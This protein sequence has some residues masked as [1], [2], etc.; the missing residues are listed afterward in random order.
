MKTALALCLLLAL[1][2]LA[3]ETLEPVSLRGY[4]TVSATYQ[5]FDSD[6]SLLR[7]VCE[8]VDKARLMQAKYVSDLSVLPGVAAQTL[9]TPR[10][11]LP[12]H[13]I[14]GQGFVAA[15]GEGRNVFILAARNE[16]NLA[17][18]IAAHLPA[19][20]L[21]LKPD[22]QVPMFLDRWDRHGFLY[23]YRP[24]TA[25]PGQPKN[26][27]YDFAQDFNFA[28]DHG[29]QGF[30][31]W[32]NEA[33]IDNAEGLMEYPYWD[34]ALEAARAMNLPALINISS[35]PASWLVNRYREQTML[36]MPQY[37]GHFFKPGDA[38]S[39]GM[40]ILSRDSEEA[41]DAEL[42]LLQ[43]AVRRY[44]SYPNIV[45]WLQPY[46][47]MFH[48]S[49]DLFLEYGPVADRS[50][51][52]YLRQRYGTVSVV[53]Q[54]WHR[55]AAHLK[56]WDAV[57]VPEFAEFM[58]WGAN[59]ID[60]RG[61]WRVQYENA[62]GG[63]IYKPEEIDA[64]SNDMLPAEPAPAEWFAANFNDANWGSIVAPGN[65]RTL[66]LPKRPAV[67]RRH[68]D[69]PQTWRSAHRKVWLY[70]W[71]FNRAYRDKLVAYINGVKVGESPIERVK[72]HWAAFE[73]SAQLR[74]GANQIALR[75]PKGYLGYRIYLSPDPPRQYP[76]LGAGKNAQWA[77]FMD[78]Y[79]WARGEQ[80]RR[81]TEMIRQ[82]DPDRQ[83]NFMHPDEF[84]GPVKQVCERYGGNFHNTGYMA[85]TWADFNQLISNS[86][87]LP[88][89]AEPG[90][91][92]AD[93]PDFLRFMGRWLTEGVQGITYFIHIG[94][95]SW[96]PDIRKLF[97]QNLP[98]YNMVG[99][100]HTPQA[101]VA[102]IYSDRNWR[103][104][105]W[106][107]N[108]D[109]NL[110]LFT[111]YWQWNPASSLR[112]LYPRDGLTEEDFAAGNAAK[113]RVILD[114]N[115]TIMDPPLIA[116]IEKWVRA[117]G[118]FVTFVQTGRHTSTQP[119]SWPISK[120][121]GYQV[122]HI[123][124]YGENGEP[125]VWR[126]LHP[127]PGQPVLDAQFWS[128]GVRASGL[129]L[130][131]N[132]PECQDLLL[133][134]DGSVAVGMRSLGKGHVI[135][136][137]PRFS[138]LKDR[139]QS[140]ETAALLS[141]ILDWRKVKPV[142]ARADGV[143]LRH[144]LSNNGLYDVWTMWNESAK[145][146]TTDLVFQPGEHP[147][148]GLE[149]ATGKVVRLVGDRLP[150][151]SFEPFET[152]VYLTPRGQLETASLDWLKLQRQWWRGA[153]TPPQ[154]KLPDVESLQT[155]TLPLTDGW[156]FQGT[157]EVRSLSIWSLSDH[158]DVKH[159]TLRKTFQ[160]PAN[161]TGGKI[162]FTLRCWA[163]A[164]FYD[165]GR[166]S[167][168][169]KVVRDFSSEGILN[170]D[171]GG[172]FQPGTSHTLELEIVGTSSL[173]GVKGNAFLS[174]LPAPRES[175]DLSGTWTPS[176]DLIHAGPPLQLPGTL[177][178][179]IAAR[180]VRVGPQY[181]GLNAIVHVEADN[182]L[183]SVIVNGVFVRRHHHGFG[184][185]TN[186]N[187]TP[188][189]HYGQDNKIEIVRW[190]GPGTV[191]VEKVELRFYRRGVYP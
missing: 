78:W 18:L 95:I 187:V 85:G 121:S 38:Y 161:W 160:V 162:R 46:G 72:L 60:L 178:G 20:D 6:S 27:P 105:Q 98:M 49:Q 22:M 124:A 138:T 120:L 45:G 13:K 75:L 151:L 88:T 66:F 143:L 77:D 86:S 156:Q 82:V 119:N 101:E 163:A 110:S 102:I 40:G 183:N 52:R 76:D 167:L 2:A 129:S 131:K 190:G 104:T 56:S 16:P 153:A 73:V 113:Y 130:R 53:S 172:A 125:S 25:P 135:Q 28:R 55:D 35:G 96:R 149:V 5:K 64:A 80:V 140:A 58:G 174:Y 84:A 17:K 159:A 43:S 23:Y 148:S 142:P 166:V 154:K 150:G 61:E 10:G 32:S 57:H 29:R 63:R 188:W 30:A 107:W 164:T 93:G 36:K 94:D 137:G 126:K 44:A 15:V 133:W 89:T 114:S 141:Q 175:I 157:N 67:F 123:D 47:E 26:Q 152:R 41:M 21:R 9:T 111:G 62:P 99:K 117:G 48:G 170:D 168:D 127:A 87:G 65:D 11:I 173:V 146:V 118:T 59:A 100:Y 92:A 37:E 145:P 4:G 51:R 106:P 8:S 109:P 165:K 179:T 122:T 3:D 189:L 136:L 33:Q 182:A 191:R 54:R 31:F 171:F 97:D 108:P 12:I 155:H 71:D 176:A 115:T 69:V 185:E 144:Y 74:P 42:G 90:G 1:P 91:G 19:G 50:Y 132:A 134:D 68:F 169:G 116:Q 81:A 128:E 139:G 39:G 112:P 7:I 83:I 103:L 180:N 70:V 14:E 181:K 147:A 158:P 34:F 177:T 184:G 186:L 79:A 24:S